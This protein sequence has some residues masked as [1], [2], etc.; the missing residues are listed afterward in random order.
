[1]KK[2]KT[3]TTTTTQEFKLFSFRRGG[4]LN[5][6]LINKSSITINEINY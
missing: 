5:F 4:I 3:T 6:D 2:C 1:M